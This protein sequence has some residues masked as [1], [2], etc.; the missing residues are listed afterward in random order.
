[1]TAIYVQKSCSGTHPFIIRSYLAQNELFGPNIHPKNSSQRF[2]FKRFRLTDNRFGSRPSCLRSHFGSSL[3]ES[4]VA[5]LH[6]HILRR[7]V[8]RHVSAAAAPRLVANL[9]APR[10]LLHWWLQ[11]PQHIA[12]N[13]GDVPAILHLHKGTIVFQRLCQQG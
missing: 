5:N 2:R 7:V 9:S 10:P 1:M 13:Q 4:K 12:V 11:P 6:G 3:V 8:N